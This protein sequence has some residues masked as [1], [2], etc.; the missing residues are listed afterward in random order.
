MSGPFNFFNFF[1]FIQFPTIPIIKNFLCQINW[2][3]L[4]SLNEAFKIKPLEIKNFQDSLFGD[5]LKFKQFYLC[6]AEVFN[7]ILPMNPC[8]NFVKTPFLTKSDKM[9]H[10]RSRNKLMKRLAYLIKNSCLFLI[11]SNSLLFLLLLSRVFYSKLIVISIKVL[12]WGD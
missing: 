9:G 11:L 6:T 12:K 5:F 1:N 2:F 8:Y 3:Q 10:W 7:H 4:R